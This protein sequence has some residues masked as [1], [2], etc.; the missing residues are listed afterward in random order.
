MT[1]DVLFRY[2]LPASFK[3][4]DSPTC[5]RFRPSSKVMECHL[6]RKSVAACSIEEGDEMAPVVLSVSLKGKWSTVKKLEAYITSA[7]FPAPRQTHP[8]QLKQCTVM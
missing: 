1:V 2:I 6:P 4:D 5:P 3:L 8:H 7:H